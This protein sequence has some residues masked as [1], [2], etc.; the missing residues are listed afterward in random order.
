[1]LVYCLSLFIKFFFLFTPFFAL[2]MFITLTKSYSKKEQNDLCRNIAI[3]V[4]VICLILFFFGGIIFDIFGITLDAF[5]VGAGILLFLTAVDLV[6]SKKTESD[7]SSEGDLA[8]VPFAVPII[9]GPATIGSLLVLG[10]DKP[11]T[12]NVIFGCLALLAAVI[13]VY[14]VLRLNAIIDRLLGKRGI[15]ILS[16]LTGLILAALASQMIMTGIKNHFN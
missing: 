8:V 10:A 5:R 16:K 6:R 2:T 12:T 15:S 3:A 7:V 13:C 14:I 4:A 11:T 1:M 9:V